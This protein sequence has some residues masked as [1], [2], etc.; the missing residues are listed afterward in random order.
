MVSRFSRRSTEENAAR[1]FLR[2]VVTMLCVVAFVV[3]GMMHPLQHSG[4]DRAAALGAAM[5][6]A[7]LLDVPSRDQDNASDRFAIAAEHCHACSVV[8]APADENSPM[9]VALK[10]SIPAGR[11][12]G[13]RVHAAF[14]ETPPPIG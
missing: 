7:S 4:T 8:A 5:A 2:R 9:I 6:A 10:R 13:L 14:V 1:C 12:G 11:Q 3:V